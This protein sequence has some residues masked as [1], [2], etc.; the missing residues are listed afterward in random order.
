V[1]TSA[2]VAEAQPQV[3]SAPL[4]SKPVRAI[5]LWGGLSANV[6]NMVGIGP[7]ITIPLALAAMGGP[8]ALLGWLTGA[9]LCLCDGLVW[10]E[11]GS[12][13]PK[14]GGPYHYLQEGFGAARLGRMFSFLY[15][16]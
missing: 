11:L 12:A 8:Q 1:N 6:L 10:A 14:S 9:V 4:D 7:F 5:G 16:W 3:P 15:L 13:M 2:V